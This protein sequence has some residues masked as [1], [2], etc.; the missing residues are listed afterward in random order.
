MEHR[1]GRGKDVEQGR[2]MRRQA[3]RSTH[4]VALSIVALMLGVACAGAACAAE[5][6]SSSS[7]GSPP[8]AAKKAAAAPRAPVDINHAS[9]AELKTLPGIGDAEADRIIAARPYLTKVD[10]ATKNV[11]PTGVYVALKDLIIAG[12]KGVPLPKQ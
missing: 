9:R 10:L 5:N 7:T 12:Q 11:L 4:G 2:A 6:K 3:S 8:P 1:A